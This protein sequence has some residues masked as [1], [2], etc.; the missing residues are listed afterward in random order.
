MKKITE[1]YGSADNLIAEFS[2]RSLKIQGSGWGWLVHCKKS[3]TL[4]FHATKDQD[5]VYLVSPSFNP[6]LTID[7]W[8]HSWYAFYKNEKKKYMTNIWKIVNWKEVERRFTEGT[9]KL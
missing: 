6:L 8:E 1:S 7:M 5:P 9:V 4:Q 2:A 3:N